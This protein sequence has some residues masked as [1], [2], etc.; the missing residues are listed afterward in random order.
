MKRDWKIVRAIL[1]HIESEDLKEY[2][3][4][5]S[6]VNDLNVNEDDF[7]GHIEIL[8]DAGIIRNAE[9][10]R[11]ANGN[12]SYCNLNG[13]FIS[14]EGHDLLDALRDSTVWS[15]ILEKSK[16]ASVSISWEFIKAAIPVIMKEILK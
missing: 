16:R 2:A 7:L 4:Q 13:V 12:I 9:V 8:I 10:R 6:Y 11:T 5:Y 14:M 15:R 3:G 1:E